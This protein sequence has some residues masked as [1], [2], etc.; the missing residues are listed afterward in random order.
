MAVYTSL[1]T[2]FAK[3][4]KDEDGLLHI[5][6]VSSDYED[7]FLN[8]GAVMNRGAYVVTY[9]WHQV[10]NAVGSNKFVLTCFHFLQ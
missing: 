5:A 1:P 10:I 2:E 4:V 3:V 9:V 8:I 7:A 6:W